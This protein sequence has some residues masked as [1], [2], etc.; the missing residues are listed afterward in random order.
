MSRYTPAL[1][2]IILVVMAG[3]FT[4]NDKNTINSLP[5]THDVYPVFYVKIDNGFNKY[6]VD[7]VLLNVVPSIDWESEVY[8]DTNGFIGT[9]AA[10]TYITD[11]DTVVEID[12]VTQEPDTSYDT[13]SVT[14]G[15]LP[16]SSYPYR[17]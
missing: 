7:S 17:N 15:F 9:L 12:P 8:S 11:I 6:G 1:I 5:K 14:Y 2:V 10:G 3:C 13:T 16:S 4:D